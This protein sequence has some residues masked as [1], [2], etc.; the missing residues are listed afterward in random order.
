MPLNLPEPGCDPPEQAGA[1]DATALFL[2]AF[3]EELRRSGVQ[4]VCICPG[5]RSTPLTLAASRSAGLQCSAHHDERSAGFFALGLARAAGRPVA[6][7]ATSGT[8]A[9]NFL[10]AVVEAHY[11]GV[12]LVLLTADRPSELRD[13]G[14]GQ[15]IDQ[16][17]LFGRY[18]RRFVEV[19]SAAA[20]PEMLRY[21]RAL[22]RRSVADSLGRPPGPVHLNWPLREPFALR[23]PGGPL[24]LRA[25]DAA[26]PAPL[27]LP[28][29][30]DRGQ[31]SATEAQLQ[32]LTAL[33]AQ[34]ERGV[35]VC[36][37]MPPDAGAAVAIAAFGERA[38][39][40]LVAD[41]LSQLRAGPHIRSAPLVAHGDILLRHSGFAASHAPDVVVSIGGA[42]VSKALRLWLD[43]SRPAHWL[44]IDP[45]GHWQ[46]PDHRATWHLHA[47]AAAVCRQLVP[48]LPA[49]RD[50][51]WRR[52]FTR[53]DAAVAA[54]LQRRF[55]QPG[56]LHEPRVAFELASCLPVG[57]TLCVSN[58][59][60]VRDVDAFMPAREG[61]L[62]VLCNRGANGI[63]GVLSSALGAA[64]A[65]AGPVALL[66]GDI[67][68]LHD[69]GALL[70]ARRHEL[71]LVIV[72]LNN[73][74]GGIFSFLPVAQAG[75]RDTFD[76]YFR[77][78]HGLTFGAA[79]AFYGIGY[80]QIDSW[81]ALRAA[82]RQCLAGGGTHLLELPIDPESN[83]RHFR[84]LIRQAGEAGA[85]QAGGR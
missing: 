19:H 8:A 71:D 35:V 41:P 30:H 78:P 2:A 34:Y 66:I 1:A 28:H 80:R 58:S 51:A 57:A 84:E 68:L 61:G 76:A 12:P 56:A 50:S 44:L 33:V 65:G 39:W 7:I 73:D 42:P 11:A 25:V 64:A 36:G 13:W 9:A 18:V 62:R 83:L 14:A 79:A 70:T 45:D 4:H 24:E 77:L 46:D 59:M 23:R 82:L 3:F 67:A 40:P 15:T 52:D 43:A 72:L 75:E 49:T 5:S 22:A 38:G 6:L 55:Q 60:P 20:T 37:S 63:D 31:L 53:A 27:P 48:R 54:F 29:G 21:A 85:A 17:H 81:E 74:G 16:L 47:D 32:A 26:M 10:P 69:I